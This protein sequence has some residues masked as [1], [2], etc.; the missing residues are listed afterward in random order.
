[1]RRGNRKTSGTDLVF[2]AAQDAEDK[3]TFELVQKDDILRECVESV[4][5]T[6]LSHG[7]PLASQ[8]LDAS[9]FKQFVRAAG[10]DISTFCGEFDLVCTHSDTVD[11]Y[12]FSKV[13]FHAAN[14]IHKSLSNP[15]EGLRHLVPQLQHFD[16]MVRS[17]NDL[18]GTGP[19]ASFFSIPELDRI[20]YIYD[21]VIDRIFTMYKNVDKHTNRELSFE[22]I[23]LLDQYMEFEEFKEFCKDFGLFPKLVSHVEL[24]K[25][26]QCAAWGAVLMDPQKQ[27]Q[28]RM[29]NLKKKGGDA[30]AA[31]AVFE[32]GLPASLSGV[33]NPIV[34]SVLPEDMQSEILMEKPAF[35]DAL[36]RMSQLMF[37]KSDQRKRLPTV[38]S[39][40]EEMF[41]LCEAPYEKI[42]Q[43]KMIQ[44]CDF[45]E[46]GI[47]MLLNTSPGA[48]L[49]PSTGALGT[50]FE[51]VI[52]G[53]NFCEKRAVFT[54]FTVAG[55]DFIVKCST[56][57]RKRVTVPVPDI[58]QPQGIH[59]DVFFDHKIYSI[60]IVKFANVRIE[61]SNNKFDYS[62]TDPEQ[63]LQLTSPCPRFSIEDNICAKLLKSFAMLCSQ[64]DKYNTKYMNRDKWKKFKKEF[65]IV[66]KPFRHDSVDSF[67]DDPFFLDVAEV[68]DAKGEV[69]VDFRGFLKV[70][71]R[72]C[73]EMVECEPTNVY[74]RMRDVCSHEITLKPKKVEEQVVA[75]DDITV[76][77]QLIELTE[78]RSVRC[79][80]VYNGPVL[81]GTLMERSGL[82]TFVDGSTRRHPFLTYRHYDMNSQETIAFQISMSESYDHLV[83]RI[84]S[85]GYDVGAACENIATRKPY[86]RCW[87]LWKNQ[88]KIG[89]VWDYSGNIAGKSWLPVSAEAYHEHYSVTMYIPH[90]HVDFVVVFMLFTKGKDIA[91]FRT[92]LTS[93]QFSLTTQ[94]YKA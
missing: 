77:R 86:G 1:M 94:L 20:L 91:H 21:G 6:I 92:A 46:P 71:T 61:C 13:L 68:H 12:G 88:E 5:F 93:K 45:V 28:S 35:M 76:A 7:D 40:V 70:V 64:D 4:W 37:S 43:R 66:E 27:G 75:E 51:L 34:A 9:K 3:K 67:A 33:T 60:Q 82:V 79:Y 87:A 58:I 18:D 16:Q 80:D 31:S 63:R 47:P 49:A 14:E 62:D 74:G 44:D 48:A 69:S 23:K 50:N 38:T 65:G 54:K 26:G 85:C 81:C 52:T 57:T 29:S 73:Y 2:N 55:N 83:S 59:V 25:A 22:Q 19:A 78:M 11:F 89:V 56:V 39:R 24:S 10:L 17:R 30:G 72:C 84:L 15:I 90:T 8:R 36:V 53:A 32:A 41:R 42:F